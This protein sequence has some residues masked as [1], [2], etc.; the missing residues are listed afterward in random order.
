MFVQC[1][2]VLL[3]CAVLAFATPALAA[4]VTTEPVKELKSTKFKAHASYASP[5]KRSTLMWMET[6]AEGDF[7]TSPIYVKSGGHL[8]DLGPTTQVHNVKWAKDGGTVEYDMALVHE[9]GL[10]SVYHVIYKLGE[11]K[12][13]RK[14]IRKDKVEASG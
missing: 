14:L 13:S 12:Q 9:Y 8:Y 3:A 7:P 2:R 1:S 11:R 4:A 10:S 6:D 5:D